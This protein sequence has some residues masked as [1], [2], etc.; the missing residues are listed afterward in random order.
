MNDG[1]GGSATT[2]QE[3]R[4]ARHPPGGVLADDP[5]GRRDREATLA[6]GNGE[7]DSNAILLATRSN[8]RKEIWVQCADFRKRAFMAPAC[9]TS[10]QPCAEIPDQV[11]PLFRGVPPALDQPPLPPAALAASP[12]VGGRS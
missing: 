4:A 11:L 8:R 7:A 6:G 2:H 10:P 9:D 5:D 12:W 3:L 1:G